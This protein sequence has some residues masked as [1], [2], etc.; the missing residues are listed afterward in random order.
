MEKIE[1]TAPR[2]IDKPIQWNRKRRLSVRG[3]L[4][5]AM[6]Q[7]VVVN[8]VTYF[9]A[10]FLQNSP[11]LTG[12]SYSAHRLSN[13]DGGIAVCVP[14]DRVAFHA[15]ESQFGELRNLN[16]T[17]LG[18]ELLVEG[19]WEYSE[20]VRAL[21]AGEILYSEEQYYSAGWQFAQWMMEHSFGRDRIAPHSA[22]AGD[23]VRGPGLGKHD[24]GKGFSW[25]RLQEQI[26]IQ[27]EAA[28]HIG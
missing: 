26:T 17:F 28:G 14:D 22:V 20:F 23:D 13:P 1:V 10:D 25:P 15:G 7:I 4:A 6:G 18:L 16:E 2:L 8:D 11:A 27:L 5:H 19:E 9:A 24:P 3:A 21:D 12:Y